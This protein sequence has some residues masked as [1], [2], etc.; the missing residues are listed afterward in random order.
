MDGTHYV[1]CF[2]SSTNMAAL[3]IRIQLIMCID[4]TYLHL[5]ADL[6]K[7]MNAMKTDTYSYSIPIY[8]H[9]V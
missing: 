2:V 3:Y 8:S 4:H 1:Q 6:M 9:Y 5:T 7:F